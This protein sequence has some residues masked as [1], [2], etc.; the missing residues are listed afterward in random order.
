[1]KISSKGELQKIAFNHSSCIDFKGFMNLSKKCTSRPCSCLVV[2][3]TF[4]SDIS[5][6]FR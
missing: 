6:R 5:L 3:A 1:M 2:D 4:A